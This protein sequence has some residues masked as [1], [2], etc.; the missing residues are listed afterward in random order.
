MTSKGMQWALDEAATRRREA[1]NRAAVAIE[2]IQIVLR[3]CNTLP[4]RSRARH[5][6]HG[7]IDALKAIVDAK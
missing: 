3:D 6:L 7:A 2:A 4:L 5:E 1:A